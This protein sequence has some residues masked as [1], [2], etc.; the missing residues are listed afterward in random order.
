MF[1]KNLFK[2]FKRNNKE[3]EINESI[4]RRIDIEGKLTQ[5]LF[6]KEALEADLNSVKQLL[7]QLDKDISSARKKEHVKLID[8]VM[9]VFG[10]ADADLSAKEVFARINKRKLKNKRPTISTVKTTIY[11]LVRRKKVQHG[12]KRGTFSLNNS[13]WDPR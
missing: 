13:P 5:D 4:Q 8:A 2:R 3:A 1:L 11:Y 7:S 10:S 12:V 6:S 9:E